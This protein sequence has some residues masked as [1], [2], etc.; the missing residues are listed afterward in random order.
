[1]AV[2]VESFGDARALIKC[3]YENLPDTEHGELKKANRRL[4]K[5]ERFSGS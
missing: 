3:G 5:S 4:P 1:M 2:K